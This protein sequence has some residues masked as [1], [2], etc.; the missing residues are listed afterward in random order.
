MKSRHWLW[1]LLLP[2]LV[3]GL[4]RLKLNVEVLDLLPQNFPVVQGLKLYQTNFANA[5]ELMIT[6]RA[7]DA[8]QAEAA[9]RTLGLA[10]RGATHLTTSVT[11]QPL[12]QERPGESAELLA[13]L[14]LNQPPEMFGAL[15]NRLAA[16]NL[17]AVLRDAREAL[18]SSLSPA[19]IA[20][21]GYDPLNLTQLPESATGGN[22]FGDGQDFFASADGAFRVLFVQARPDIG[23]Y[24]QCAAWLQSV[25]A[26]EQSL[27][28]QN[29]IPGDTVVRYTGRPAFV[30]EIALGMEGDMTSSVGSTLVII[31]LLFYWAHRRF[32]PLLWLVTLLF[33]ILVATLSLGA[34]IFGTLSV[35]S[36]GFAAILLGLAVDYG[37]VLYQEALCAPHLTAG[38]LRRELAPSIIW[39][40]V[41][42]AGAF[43]ILNL[44]G[45]PGLGQLGSLVAI[46]IGLAAVVMLFAFLPPL[47]RSRHG[48]SAAPVRAARA[49]DFTGAPRRVWAL[50]A[51]VLVVAAVVLARRPPGFDNSAEALRPKKSEAMA[52]VEEIKTRLQRTQEPMW[53]LA[54][55]RDESEVAHRLEVAEA[56]LSRAVSNGLIAKFTLPSA[57]WPRPDFQAANRPAAAALVAQQETWRSAALAAGFTSNSFALTENMVTTWRAALA[58]TNVFWP[59][60]ASSQWIVEKVAARAPGQFLALGL[61][62]SATNRVTGGKS[63]MLGVAE[64]LA[65]QGVFISGWETLG[66]AI[67]ARVKRDFWKVLVPMAALLLISLWFAFRNVTEVLLSL[68][69]L[70]FS[71]LALGTIMSLAGWSW[72]LLNLMALPLLLGAGVDYSIHLQLALRRHGGNLAVTR[73][74]VGRALLLCAGTT[75][76]GFGSNIWSSNAGLTSLGLVCATGIACAYLTANYLLPIW[77]RQL[78]AKKLPGHEI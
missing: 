17:P 38:E 12:W 10:L 67:F 75:V 11:W 27:R 1:L 55:G 49:G 69:T 20:R 32:R 54:T 41:T 53:M 3:A 58:G 46:G 23:S 56:A 34:L 4:L 68:A 22:A 37:M 5:R 19:D 61:I 57:L 28:A 44:G 25:K 40:A 14:W 24:R 59:T 60:N 77:W 29:E 13:F 8:A 33:L 45:L 42:T 18:T 30:S 50:T 66:N 15:T 72:N 78:A 9:A 43:A 47:L 39:S 74:S 63:S 2:L 73:R 48:L 76:A 26:V 52:T 64:E 7:P 51:L 62:Y 70:A 16:A 65:A 36:V 6:V 21:R 31:V 35:I 71:G